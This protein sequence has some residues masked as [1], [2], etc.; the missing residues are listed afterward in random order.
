[1]NQGWSL[2][3]HFR[4]LFGFSHSVLPT[5][6]GYFVSRSDSHLDYSH[7]MNL[8]LRYEILG[9]KGILGRFSTAIS[10]LI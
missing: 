6:T 1:M 3:R 10:F 9:R 5:T 7:V 2:G 4:Y 8:S